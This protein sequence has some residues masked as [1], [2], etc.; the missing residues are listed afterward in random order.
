[1]ADPKHASRHALIVIAHPKPGSLTHAVAREIAA[2]V[3]ADGIHTSEFADLTAEGFDPRFTPDDVD[4]LI[5]KGPPP[6]DA[7]AEQ[8]RI[9]RAQALVLVYPVYWWSFPAILKGWIDRVFTDGWAYE[10][11][12]RAKK[13]T[14]LPVHLVAL[15][16]ADSGTYKR[17]GY[18]DAMKTQIDHGIFDY[19]GAPVAS[20]T[21]LIDATP[22]D[23]LATARSLGQRLFAPVVEPA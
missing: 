5:K 18:F 4:I 1:M 15:G 8:Q 16:G 23:H 10:D 14:H 7:R 19:C 13:L 9:E 11:A 21:Y 2:G 12:T 20:S 6:A 3:A 17:H 22:E